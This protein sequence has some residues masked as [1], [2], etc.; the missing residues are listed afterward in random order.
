[1]KH[2]LQGLYTT[3]RCG[4][5]VASQGAYVCPDYQ[6]ANVSLGVSSTKMYKAATPAPVGESS[7]KKICDRKVFT[8]SVVCKMVLLLLLKCFLGGSI[9]SVPGCYFMWILS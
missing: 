9:F 7:D 2:T 3:A 6:S 5:Q 8:T 4:L 1:M